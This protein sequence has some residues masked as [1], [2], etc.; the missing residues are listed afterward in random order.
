MN[1][2]MN[3][4]AWLAVGTLWATL[5][6]APAVADDS[7]LFIGTSNGAAGTQPNILLVIDNSISMRDDVRTQ[8]TFDPSIT[9]D[10]GTT[11]C[12]TD[13]VYY[14]FGN[15]AQPDCNTTRWFDRAALKC[16]AALLAFNR[17]N[18]GYYTDYVSGYDNGTDKRWEALSTTTAGR[19]RAV[20]CQDDAGI[21]G[22]GVNTTNL[23]ARNGGTTNG[24]WGT[25]TSTGRIANTA[26]G[27]SPMDTQ[28]VTMYSGQYMAYTYGPT[29]LRPKIDVAK[30]VASSL[31]DSVNGVN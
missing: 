25:A 23:Y 7:E 1:S 3:R 20:E 14:I 29:L 18:G 5:S 28:T 17:V 26:W 8:A 22:D 6:G 19:S 27:V 15:A 30:D 12:R 11:G 10:P 2:Q 24:Y 31:L 21:H 16:N 4:A 9:Y 13:R